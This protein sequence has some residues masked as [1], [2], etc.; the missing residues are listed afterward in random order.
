MQTMAARTGLRAAIPTAGRVGPTPHM[1]STF[2]LATAKMRLYFVFGTILQSVFPFTLRASLCF[3]GTR[4]VT[5]ASVEWYGPD[6]A[7]FL[8]PFTNP[9]AYLKVSFEQPV[10]HIGY[11]CPTKGEV[12]LDSVVARDH[13]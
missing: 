13:P 5:R 10:L 6:R 9:P 11:L 2:F 12:H 4:Q 3:Q 8:G 1:R 7:K